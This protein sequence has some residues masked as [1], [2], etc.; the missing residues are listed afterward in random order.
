M[1]QKRGVHCLAHLV[2][3]PKTE[4]N[5]GH[6]TR[7]LSPRT[8]LFDAATRFDEVNRVLIMFLDARCDSKYIWVKNDV[9]RFKT[10]L[11]DQNFIG[12]GANFYFSFLCVGLSL[13]VKSHDDSRR[14]VFSNDFGL[15]DKLFLTFFHRNR[16][17]DALALNAFQTRF[18]DV[19][20]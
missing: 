13:F 10:D 3:A 18:D 9:I 19:E 5:I 1:V 17:D 20:F 11:F 15:F 16:I 2:V 14:A 12:T 8:A 4:R 6:A 7:N